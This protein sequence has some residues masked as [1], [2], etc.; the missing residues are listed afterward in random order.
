MQKDLS[1][2]TFNHNHVNRVA[3]SD[4]YKVCCFCLW[5]TLSKTEKN[6]KRNHN[7]KTIGWYLT[8]WED[9]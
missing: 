7:E 9:I 4:V 8:L 3:D 2:K 1:V 5:K 6:Y